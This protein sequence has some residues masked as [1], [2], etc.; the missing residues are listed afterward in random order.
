[1]CV[2]STGNTE[3]YQIKT[4]AGI[5]LF[6]VRFYEYSVE[7]MKTNSMHMLLLVLFVVVL[8]IYIYDLWIE[9]TN[10]IQSR[11]DIDVVLIRAHQHTRALS[12]AYI[13]TML[14]Y[15]EKI[16]RRKMSVYLLEISVLGIRFS[17]WISWRFRCTIHTAYHK[18]PSS[19]CQSVLIVLGLLSMPKVNRWRG[20]MLDLYIYWLFC[21]CFS[22]FSIIFST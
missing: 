21:F 16:H 2:L 18:L 7:P 1:M 6:V 15:N 12:I 11:P 8:C 4:T 9:K 17:S 19:L 20:T 14:K 10:K 5:T 13:R 22:A 3:C